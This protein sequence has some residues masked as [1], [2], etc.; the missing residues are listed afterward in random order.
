MNVWVVANLSK[1]HFHSTYSDWG[2][3]WTGSMYSSL[4]LRRDS[5]ADLAQLAIL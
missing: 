5:L 1:G 2:G 4:Q 3:G